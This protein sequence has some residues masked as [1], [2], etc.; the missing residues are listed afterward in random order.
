MRHRSTI[1]A[2]LLVC[3]ATL[4]HARGNMKELTIPLKFV[5]QEGVHSASADIPPAMLERSVEVRVEDARK[6]PDPL[7]IGQGTGGDDKLFPIRGDRDPIAFIQEMVSSVGKEWSLK[8]DPPPV[9]W[10]TLQVTRFS[11]DESNKA[12]GSMYGGEVKLAFTLKDAKGRTLAEGIGSGSAHRY[13][14]AHSAEN[15]NEVLSDALKEAYANV[16]AD[17]ALQAAWTSGTPAAS[18][19]STTPPARPAE[20]TEERLR[21]LD[22]LLKKGVITKEEY[23]KKRAEILKEM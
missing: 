14:K 22:D 7:V 18:S 9:R 17:S 11:I 6:L 8:Q 19:G 21:K 10:L 5:P 16:L 2:A 23:D 20:T 12:L 1:I 15:M 3:S 13:G 4:L